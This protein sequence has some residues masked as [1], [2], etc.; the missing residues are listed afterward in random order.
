MS[1]VWASP[2]PVP[3]SASIHFLL[4]TQQS[5]VQ[6]APPLLPGAGAPGRAGGIIRLRDWPGFHRVSVNGDAA[7]G[8]DAGVATGSLCLFPGRDCPENSG[9]S[10][11]LCPH[12]VIPPLAFLPPD[13]LLVPCPPLCRWHVACPGGGPSFSLPHTQI[14]RS[15][16]LCAF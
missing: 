14:H 8:E 4:V 11:S 7:C 15:S 5:V 12:C 6:A 13:L 10:G 3:E 2:P 9:N 16:L 1:L